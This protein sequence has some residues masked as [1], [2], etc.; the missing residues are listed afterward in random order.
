MSATEM[1]VVVAVIGI[2]AVPLST[3]LNSTLK[4][5]T[6]S[7]LKLQSSDELR[8][9][10]DKIERD[11]MEMNEVTFSTAALIEFRLDSYNLPGYSDTADADGDGLTN[12]ADADDDNDLTTIYAANLAWR[13]GY[14]LKDDD[15]DNDGEIDVQCRYYKSGT[16]L[17]RDFNYN[18]AGWGQHATV[19]AINVSSLTF[20]Y[21][22]SKNENLGKFIDLGNDGAA[23]T[24]DTGESDGI[25][26]ARE[27][28]WVQPATGA[29]DRSGLI[30]TATE[31]QY[32]MTIHFAI[33]QDKNRDGKEDY[34]LETQVAPPLVPVKRYF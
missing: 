33:A 23:G 6:K 31:R 14:D 22:G 11:F 34:R 8:Q 10:F 16:S 21:Y 3:F 2:L 7:N 30:D 12:I 1:V 19:V 15:D 25:I 26:S 9:A 24:G 28:D 27:I 20:T 32:I 13:G 29:G 17:M 18:E 5:L 4:N